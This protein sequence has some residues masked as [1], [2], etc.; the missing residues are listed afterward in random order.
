MYH[1][2]MRAYEYY[3]LFAEEG[4]VILD[5]DELVDERAVDLLAGGF[6][7]D[8]RFSGRSPREL[9]VIYLTITGRFGPHQAVS[10]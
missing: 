10:D 2:R 4:A 8:Q 5:T 7:V 1:N 6:A 9:A 3:E